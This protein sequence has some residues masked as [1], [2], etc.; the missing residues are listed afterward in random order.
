MLKLFLSYMYDI[1]IFVLLFLHIADKTFGLDKQQ[2][3]I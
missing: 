2:Q 3:N 1:V